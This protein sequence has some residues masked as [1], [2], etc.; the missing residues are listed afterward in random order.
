M[1]TALFLGK[2][3]RP[4]LACVG[5]GLL[6]GSFAWLGIRYVAAL[7][8]GSL[9]L[10]DLRVANFS[11]PQH[12]S[13]DIIL[14]VINEDTLA[15]FP[16]RSPINR[17]LIADAV[18]ELAA[19]NVRAVGV[20]VIFDQPTNPDDDQ[21]LLT[22]FA[23]FPRP[24][25]VAVGQAANGLTE[26]QLKFQERYVAQQIQGLAGMLITNGV[27]RH[28]YPGEHTSAGS[29]PGFAA[30]LAVAVGTPSPN[31]PEQLYYRVADGD[32]PAIR[33]YPIQHLRVLPRGWFD[34]V[35]V[36]IG[37]DLPNQDSFRTP[38]SAKGG[39]L[40]AGVNIHAQA[41]AQLLDGAR[42][43]SV[44]WTVDA[45][46]VA[47][48][49]LLGVGLPFL[50][51]HLHSKTGLGLAIVSAYWVLGFVGFARGGPLLPL[52]A[53]TFGFLLANGF[54][55]AYARRNAQLE[56]RFVRAAFSRYVSPSVI[57]QMLQNPGRLV[58]GGEKREMSFIFSDLEGFTSLSEQLPP[59]AAVALLQEY[60]DGM[61]KIAFASGATVDRLVGD[62]IA[63]FFGA[64]TAQGD[65]ASRAVECAI[66]WDR[67]AEEFR[68]AQRRKG[69]A[70]GVTRIGVHTGSAIVG[71]VG[72]AERFHYTAHG[73]CVNTAARLEG[74]NKYLGTRICLSRKVAEAHAGESFLPIGTLLL[75]GKANE[76]E[77]VTHA[78]ILPA[79]SRGAY[80]AAFAAIAVDRDLA[81]RQFTALSETSPECRLV[82]FYLKRLRRG[83]QGTTIVLEEK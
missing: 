80:L 76:L 56:K 5:L 39:A 25:V 29:K 62:G 70:V 31:K 26:R 74:A 27:V 34:N 60:L 61:I 65:H 18:D 2:H 10:D 50:R 16:F 69:V 75:K 7:R 33:S 35:I 17:R 64:P 51:M 8:Q 73:D 48:A 12:Q 83:E 28:I 40:M 59:E 55:T 52:L 37:A 11:P 49:A 66:A 14:L 63:V 9:L 71:N 57:E 32:I 38:L 79:E 3:T 67:Y 58:L 21:A 45:A 4:I 6:A 41:L 53:P 47:L 30:A 24:L 77:C 13:S 81:E 1:R 44:P 43:P 20:D 36:L 19:R 46:I 54:G 23:R 68:K 15:E 78:S 42:F 22:A 82:A 72:S